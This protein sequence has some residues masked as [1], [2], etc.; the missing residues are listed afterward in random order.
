MEIKQ[1]NSS[2]EL[3]RLMLMMFLILHHFIRILPQ[4]ST[5]PLITCSDI[6]FH[7]AASCFIIISGYY[8]IKFKVKKLIEIFLYIIFYSVLLCLFAKYQYNTTTWKDVIKSFLP[9]TNGYYWFI[10]IYIQLYI[11][12]PFLNTLLKNL[13]NK[14]FSL[15]I[16]ALTFL[17]YYIGIIRSSNSG[18][19]GKHIQNFILLYCIGN[20][21]KRITQRVDIPTK[22][23]RYYTISTIF[24]IPTI[25]CISL[26]ISRN[27]WTYIFPLFEHYHS[28]GLILISIA[29][30]LFFATYHYT[31]NA[32]N[33]ISKSALAIYLFHE[34][35]FVS[36]YIY[37]DFYSSLY[38]DWEIVALYLI[39]GT[40]IVTIPAIIIDQV[41]ILLQKSVTNIIS[42][43]ETKYY[44][45]Y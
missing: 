15:F 40:C 28:P 14:Q 9:V 5:S 16:A 18:F 20:G 32:I 44:E 25:A 11:F 36:K 19:D 6:L 23:I 37:K 45:K 8:G 2:I 39:S 4:E 33:Y 7:S 27:S 24:I 21:I 29:I 35:P 12:A 31:N 42:K 43:N 30:F 3:M 34:H 10:S 38:A 1:R 13:S 17:V 26:Y 22:A 41:R